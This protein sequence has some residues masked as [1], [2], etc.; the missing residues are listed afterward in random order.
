MNLVSHYNKIQNSLMYGSIAVKY[1]KKDDPNRG[2]VI[3]M[4]ARTLRRRWRITKENKH[5][6]DAIYYFQKTIELEPLD[7]PNRLLHFDDL[8]CALRERYII[9]YNDEDFNQARTAFENAM[10]KPFDAIPAFLSGL[11]R[12]YKDKASFATD[13][14]TTLLQKSL[15]IH[16]RAVSSV[17]REFRGSMHFIYSNLADA[18][19]ESHRIDENDPLGS[20]KG[21]VEET[22]RPTGNMWM[23]LYQLGVL[24]GNKFIDNG[25][26]SEPDA[27]NSISFLR[28]ALKESPNNRMINSALA[29]IL[30]RYGTVINLKEM[31]TEAYHLNESLIST[32]IT[33]NVEVLQ[34]L[35]SMSLTLT[36]RFGLT[37]AP[38]DINKA[39]SL[40]ERALASPSLAVSAKWKF[41]QILG[42]QFGC[43]FQVTEHKDDL[44]KGISS[45]SEA[46][47]FDGL[48]ELDKAMTL[49]E[50]GK[51]LFQ[52]YKLLK[53]ETD[54]EEAI[55]S[56]ETASAL[57]G[58]DTET[59]VLC[60]NDLA[61]AFLVRFE[62]TGNPEFVQQAI[63][64]YLHG[65]SLLEPTSLIL[66]QH[67]PMFQLGLGNAFF[68]KYEVWDQAADL[69]QTIAYY[70]N[71]ADGT[72]SSDVRLARRVGSLACAL[73]HKCRV[74]NNK[75]FLEQA[76]ECVSNILTSP[77]ITLSPEDVSFLQN[78]QGRFYMHAFDNSNEDLS[79]L[80]AAAE[81]FRLA[82]QSGC[83]Q[84]TL[85]NPPIINRIRALL[86][87]YE[88][89]KKEEDL[90]KV[91]K[92]S[93]HITNFMISPNARDLHGLLDT[94]GKLATL[95]YDTKNNKQFG[96]LGMVFYAFLAKDESAF[97]ERRIWASLQV[98]RLTYE[99]LNQPSMARNYLVSILN[100][101]PNAIL[102]CSNRADQL[103]ASQ[104]FGIL[105][106]LVISFS[107][108]AGDTPGD[109]L[110]WFEQGRSIIWSRLLDT[111]TDLTNLRKKHED[112][113]LK[114]DHILGRL[115]RLASSTSSALAASDSPALL[116][117]RQHQLSLEY[118]DTVR[119]IREREGFENFLLLDEPSQL[120]EYAS[121]G[122]IVI[123]NS[124]KY[125]ADA[126]IVTLEG[127]ISIPLPEFTYDKCIERGA[128]VLEA[129]H[130]MATE[131]ERASTQM[132]GVLT[133]L[134]VAVAE[135]VLDKVN[136]TGSLDA[137]QKLPRIW[138]LSNKW[139]S[140][141]PIHAA[142]DHAHALRTGEACT[143]MDRAVSSYIPSIRAL[144]FLRKS[145]ANL[146]STKSHNRV[147]ASA[148]LVKM[149]TTLDDTDL[150]N[151]ENEVS[152]VEEFL[153]PCFQ[154][155]SLTR[156]RRKDV[157]SLLENASVAHFAC[158]GVAS[159]DD[160]SLSKLKLQDWKTHPLDVRTLL[161]TSCK[162]LE[163]VY[164]S[165]CETA[166]TAVSRTREECIHLS[167]GFQMAGVPYTVASIWK[168]EDVLSAEVS[169]DFY[170]FLKGNEG[171]FDFGRSAEALHSASLNARKRG[172]AALY[173]GAFVHFGV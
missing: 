96:A 60:I 91:V 61:N 124:T 122:T 173:W 114:F 29:E 170:A 102:M 5:L 58:K 45:L 67:Q 26:N 17:T 140:L 70:Q 161:R 16:L 55:K 112:L 73:Q 138:W 104:Q 139:T 148:V 20:F 46:L 62:N 110:R 103:R 42:I 160:P 157:L 25:R 106:G 149:P 64:Q 136:I 44:K 15:E 120:A 68:M 145:A 111:K 163:F 72:D 69:N 23:F 10:S 14:K 151:V 48:S 84:P 171:G 125:R 117:L 41:Q 30:E 81:C 129:C 123:L 40:A 56:L 172:A 47:A 135:P 6:D 39:I 4:F 133:W 127:V 95:V 19:L 83:T 137:H 142:G 32:S 134:W 59:K 66:K 97:P 1:V 71:A 168:I 89:T 154:V 65:F 43:R 50:Y 36:K 130:I 79:L 109:T 147:A 88:F 113:A 131:P 86:G 21:E 2:I 11:G 34:K 33:D 155:V 49:R 35:Q 162:H 159:A 9:L 8:G 28:A 77:Y 93:P 144:D 87:K 37:N 76:Q 116:Q 105:P 150:P 166:T 165:A 156:P 57:C 24:L 13:E 51:L 143:V 108:A 167:A 128:L 80:D 53:Q 74:T 92:E 18:C 94:A 3:S 52:N 153:K 121:Q 27:L 99:V 90:Q 119:I 54:L 22:I 75:K 126:V 158:H 38:D 152:T 78:I 164:L 12:L 169:G 63:D 7:E 100:L 132:D 85:I 115:D 101:L 31:L 107:L 82:A 141:F 118:N 146:S 98:A